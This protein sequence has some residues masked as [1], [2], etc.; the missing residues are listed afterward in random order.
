MG[1]QVTLEAS[2][3]LMGTVR[4]LSFEIPEGWS[5]FPLGLVDAERSRLVG[6][7]RWVTSGYIVIGLASSEGERI[8]LKVDVAEPLRAFNLGK[9]L[10]KQRRRAD[11]WGNVEING[12]AGAYTI[13]EVRR[14]IPRRREWVEATLCF[15]CD[16]TERRI[17][18]EVIGERKESVAQ[19]LNSLFKLSCH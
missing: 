10:R 19:I 9:W 6:A 2:N 13:R 5:A 14:R 12:H 7:D 16:K 18:L 15:Y 17:R 1:T 11:S 4:F 8:S 3:L